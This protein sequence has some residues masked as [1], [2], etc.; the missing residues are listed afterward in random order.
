MEARKNALYV[1]EFRDKIN[2]DDEILYC[3]KCL[4]KTEVE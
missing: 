4:K 2:E 3:R 1:N